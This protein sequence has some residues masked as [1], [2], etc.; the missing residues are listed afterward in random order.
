MKSP[1]LKKAQK[2]L[3]EFMANLADFLG[4]AHVFAVVVILII[5][6][7]IAR[8]FLDYDTWFDIIDMATFVSTFLLLFVVQGSQ[9]ADTMAIQDKLD[10][11]I[12]SMPKANK[13]KEQEEK[14]LKKGDGR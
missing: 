7:F 10:E 2:R 12:D 9:N 4:K 1:L 6:W 13:S 8:L 3:T 11:L 5:I 14:R